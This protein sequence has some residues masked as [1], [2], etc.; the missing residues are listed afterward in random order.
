MRTWFLCKIKYEKEDDKGRLNKVT[1]AYLLDALTFTEAEARIYEQL[2]SVIRG[3][4]MVTNIGKSKYV[5]I[6]QYDDI[7]TWFHCK[8]VYVTADE[9]TGKE[10]KVTNL[11]LVSAHNV[12]EAYERLQD[13]LKTMLVPYEITA[14][15]QS[16]IVEIFPYDGELEQEIPENLKPL[17]EVQEEQ[18]ESEEEEI[19][20]ENL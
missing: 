4:F 8:V 9:K 17:S 20:E 15:N 1:E 10:K 7:D 3:E 5:D 11:M 12:K 19:E 13:N 16:P 6:F 14:I 18:I 2:G